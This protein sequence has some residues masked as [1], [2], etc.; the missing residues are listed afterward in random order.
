[1]D[2][3]I[4]STYQNLITTGMT[5]AFSGWAYAVVWGV[6]RITNQMQQNSDE[7]Q[8]IVRAIHHEANRTTHIESHLMT[9][10]KGEFTPY[11]NGEI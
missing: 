10:T 3:D 1:M 5:V 6:R 4:F 11:H 7:L 8:Q 9:V 2:V